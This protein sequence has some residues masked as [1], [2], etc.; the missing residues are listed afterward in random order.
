MLGWATHLHVIEV[1]FVMLIPLLIYLSDVVFLEPPASCY[2]LHPGQISQIPCL[3]AVQGSDSPITLNATFYRNSSA[4]GIGSLPPHHHL[5]VDDEENV[6]GLVIPAASQDSHT[7]YHCEAGG[8]TS[9]HA[10]VFIGSKHYAWRVH[11]YVL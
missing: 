5:L 1:G 8:M 3:A 7:T 6:I 10:A 11:T 4:I 9:L 2:Y